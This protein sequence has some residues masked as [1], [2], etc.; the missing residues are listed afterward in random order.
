[1]TVNG[2]LWVGYV[3][4]ASATLSNGALNVSNE[5]IGYLQSGS[6]TQSSGTTQNVSGTLYLG[7]IRRQR[8][9]GR[10][11][12]ERRTEHRGHSLLW[13]KRSGAGGNVPFGGRDAD[14]GGD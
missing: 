4:G 10:L 5:M 2:S 7:G 6:F 9:D 3:S 12:A 13:R 14:G 11:L 1:M 8:R